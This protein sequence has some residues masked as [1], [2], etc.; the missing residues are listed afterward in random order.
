MK[1][2]IFNIVEIC[3][4]NYLSVLAMKWIMFMIGILLLMKKRKKNKKNK[5]LIQIM[6]QIRQ[7][8]KKKK[9]KNKSDESKINYLIYTELANLILK[10]NQLNNILLYLN[11]FIKKLLEKTHSIG[12]IGNGLNLNLNF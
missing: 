4:R 5:I 11:S 9:K 8:K 12:L 3:L 6:Q 7:R 1:N 10:K 2:Q